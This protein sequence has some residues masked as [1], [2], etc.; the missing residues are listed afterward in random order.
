[1][2]LKHPMPI[3]RATAA[4]LGVLACA[5]LA[6]A[7]DQCSDMGIRGTAFYQ[8]DLYGLWSFGALF[9]PTLN[10]GFVAQYE[11]STGTTA[12]YKFPQS[13][14]AYANAAAPVH[15]SV[16][17]T[18]FTN[19]FYSSGNIETT[20]SGT[21]Y[22]TKTGQNCSV[23]T[24][25]SP[26]A[27]NYSQ[28]IGGVYFS[29]GVINGQVTNVAGIGSNQTNLSIESHAIPIRLNMNNISISLSTTGRVTIT[30][31]PGTPDGLY[32]GTFDLPFSVLSCLGATKCASPSFWSAAPSTTSNLKGE[33]RIRVSGGKPV[34][35][36]THCQLL[37]PNQITIPHGILTPATI[38]GHTATR[39]IAVGC[40]G[41]PVSVKASVKGIGIPNTGG[42]LPGNSGVLTPLS[43]G[44][45][46]KLTI[47]GQTE[48]TTAVGASKGFDIQSE[49]ISGNRLPKAG[50][51]S[52]QAVVTF[53]WE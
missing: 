27:G 49:L 21:L 48:F 36:D 10:A 45:D 22:F 7:T 29:V 35:P 6:R 26:L 30:V 9:V 14:T 24:R 42:Q 19:D 17:S 23:A 34:D 15:G 5:G 37:S 39:S 32:A 4:L 2:K 53:A 44:M 20:G 13:V 8:P 40:T 1:M 38:S 12:T 18:T 50:P 11:A 41:G 31:P 51:Y 3:L 16:T 52:G 25:V 28:N 47:N 46:S 43:N 33:I